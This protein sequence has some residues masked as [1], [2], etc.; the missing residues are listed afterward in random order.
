MR[1]RYWIGIAAGIILGLIFIISGLGKVLYQAEFLAS[2][3][4]KSLLTPLLASL[5]SYVL[6]AAE[7]LLG[8]LLITGVA[9]RIAA[10]LSVSSNVNPRDIDIRSLQKQLVD[11]GF[12][13]GNKEK[14]AKLGLTKI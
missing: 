6:P 3:L 12:Y 7:L 13:L 1:K 8:L 5:V 2:M 4:P 11:Q 14:L 10:S 9:G